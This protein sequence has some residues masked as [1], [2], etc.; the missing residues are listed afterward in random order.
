MNSGDFTAR[1]TISRGCGSNCRRPVPERRR[2]L[3][4]QLDLPQPD[5]APVG[6]DRSRAET[7]VAP[8][9]DDANRRLG[10]TRGL[11]LLRGTHD[12]DGLVVR[13][14]DGA[15]SSILSEIRAAE[16]AAETV[17]N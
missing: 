12:V 7:V 5:L 15:H 17:L 13:A 1:S 8:L 2:G 6:V 14:V 10:S 9:A 16:R 3:Y 11:H 4:P